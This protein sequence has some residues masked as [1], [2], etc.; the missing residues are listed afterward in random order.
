MRSFFTPSI[1]TS[2]LVTGAAAFLWLLSCFSPKSYAQ[3]PS[4]AVWEATSL[5]GVE[6][7]TLPL[8]G[9]TLFAGTHNN[10]VFR[11]TDNGS[12]WTAVNSGLTSPDILSLAVNGT[13]LFAGTNGSGLCRSVNSGA[14]WTQ[15]D[16]ARPFSQ[17]W[18]VAV[19]G[20]TV[21][22]IPSDGNVTRSVDNGA[23][24]RMTGANVPIASTLAVSGSTFFAGTFGRGIFRSFDNGATWTAANAGLGNSIGI[25]VIVVNGTTL[26]A[27]TSGGIFRST[28]NGTTWTSV[29]SNF[30]TAV[31]SLAVNGTTLF[32]GT[33]GG[34]F[35][36]DNGGNAWAL[37]N[38]GLANL[39][40]SLSPPSYSITALTMN[41]NTLFAGSFGRGVYRTTI[42]LVPAPTLTVN[43]SS[44]P[45]GTTFVGTAGIPQAY[46]LTGENLT[47]STVTIAAPVGVLLATSIDGAYSPTLTFTVTNGLLPQTS[48]YARLQSAVIQPVRGAIL[49]QSGSAAVSVSISGSFQMIPAP[50]QSALIVSPRVLEFG[51]IAVGGVVM[52][53]SYTVTGTIPAG[54]T[55]NAIAPPGVEI[56]SSPSGPFTS[57]LSF[58]AANGQVNETVYVRLNSSTPIRHFGSAITNVTNAVGVPVDIFGRILA[59]PL[60]QLSVMPPILDFGTIL[61]NDSIPEKTFT[62]TGSNLVDPVSVVAP[63]GV[64]LRNPITGVWESPLTLLPD[65]NRSTSQTIRVRLESSSIIGEIRG[66]I[67]NESSPAT[68]ADVLVLG[69]ILPRPLPPIPPQLITDS[70]RIEFGTILV[71]TTTN[72]RSYILSGRN[73]TTSTVTIVAPQTGVEIST[74]PNGQ[75]ST[76]LELPV[77]IGTLQATTIFVR[78]NTS[79]ART[80]SGDVIA[81]R[82]GSTSASVSVFGMVQRL[83]ERLSV[84]RPSVALDTIIHFDPSPPQTYLVTGANLIAPVVVTAPEGVLLFS[85]TTG[86]WTRT[87]VLPTS[88]TGSLTQTIAVRL[89]S[90]VLRTLLPSALI[91]HVSGSTSAFVQVSGAVVQLFLP[92]GAETTLELRLVAPRSLL[93]IRDTAHMQLWLKDSRLFTPR[94]IGRFMRTLR[95]TVRIDTNNLAILGVV[96]GSGTRASLVS[97]LPQVPRTPSPLELSVVRVDTLTTSNMLLAEI[98]VMATLGE[99]T[100][101][102]IRL[103]QPTEWRASDGN[104]SNARVIWSS[105]SLRIEI[106]PLVKPRPRSAF[107]A[108]VAPN[109]SN[110]AVQLHYT[111]S[112]DASNSEP[113]TLIVSDM[114]GSILQHTELGLRKGNTPYQETVRLTGFAAG[115]YRVLLVS[116]SEVIVGRMDIVK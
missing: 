67:A 92:A 13:T 64:Q 29:N 85:T 88:A 102:T 19:T 39:S 66:I 23:S 70:N 99:T 27:G 31:W 52:P 11:S 105:D 79:T 97:Q 84:S 32:A 24:W 18:A 76:T 77:N 38:T 83:P 16:A 5:T 10:G 41:G 1:R 2:R 58:T 106:A 95:A 68:P 93:L 63:A 21:L 98:I 90:S 111:R 69:A 26:F 103:T 47:T 107:T 17:V 30:T 100:N 96:P 34:V 56:S 49:H 44:L 82:A 7:H 62:L 28:D 80:V 65:A 61:Q 89:D 57:S 43:R 25:F 91:Q 42:A 78:L 15:T 74:S 33:S 81:H 71:G 59:P 87:L 46:T 86:T 72:I 53:K 9:T 116:P 45:L 14:S 6:I 109:P 37:M 8:S 35:R 115:A 36:S 20:S 113:L 110:G 4:N 22:A 40:D 114:V 94:L 12:S 60:A 73:L 101:N 54:S 112:T 48:I 51:D 50:T 108:I 3:I 75:F 55:V 104:A